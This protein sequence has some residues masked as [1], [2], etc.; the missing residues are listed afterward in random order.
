MGSR[1]IQSD[2]FP[3]H[4]CCEEAAL[5]SR[6]TEETLESERLKAR[7]GEM[8][9]ALSLRHDHGSQCMSDALQKEL[10]FLGAESSPTRCLNNCGQYTFS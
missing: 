5:A 4:G 2:I 8:L 7:L 3:L 6:P 1:E 10:R 9:L